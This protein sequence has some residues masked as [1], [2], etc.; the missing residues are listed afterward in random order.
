VFTGSPAG[1]YGIARGLHAY[2]AAKA[3]VLGLIRAMA[4]DYAREGI[5]VNGVMPGITETPMNRWWMEDDDRRAELEATIPLG[6]AAR[7]E[8]IA[9]VTAFL[10][11]D[12]AS[13][14]TGALWAVDGGLTAV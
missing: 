14:V 9:S 8:E 5:R 11:S 2:S 4:A 3:G 7:A 1:L 10:A 6:R 12:E 13:Y